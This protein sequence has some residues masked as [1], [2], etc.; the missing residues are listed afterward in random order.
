M[1]DMH[2]HLKNG[3]K[4]QDV[5]EKYIEKCKEKNINKVVFLDHGNRISSKHT[6]ILYSKETIDSFNDRLA[7]FNI[8]NELHILKGIEID[9]STDLNFRKETFEIL[10]YGNFDWIVGAIHSIKFESLHGYL[11]AVTDMLKNYNINAIAHL[12]LDETYKSFEKLLI[13]ILKICYEKNVVTEINTN[14]RS[15]WNDKQLYY[16]LELMKKYNVN[17]VF[18][19]DAHDIDEIGYMIDETMKKVLKWN[20]RK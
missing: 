17:Y 6:P 3:I 19:S 7:T 13:K 14:D 11:E 4:N 15:R 9:Y 5:F 8:S 12:K 10:D 18:S 2:I 20:S 1:E 16:M